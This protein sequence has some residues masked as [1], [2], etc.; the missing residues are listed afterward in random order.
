V[1]IS[2]TVGGLA[3]KYYKEWLPSTAEGGFRGPNVKIER[4]VRSSKG[5]LFE[6]DDT[7]RPVLCRDVR[8][9]PACLDAARDRAKAHPGRLVIVVPD[10]AMDDW[11]A[12]WADDV[13]HPRRTISITRRTDG[14]QVRLVGTLLAFGFGVDTSIQI[15]RL[16]HEVKTGRPRGAAGADDSPKSGVQELALL[17]KQ[18]APAKRRASR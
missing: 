9:F 10:L 8:G 2:L 15:E 11:I 6:S 3:P 5:F 13:G 14:R 16:E 4:T 12:R 7:P 17:R 18:A 1:K